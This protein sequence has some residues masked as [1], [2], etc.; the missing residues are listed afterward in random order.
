MASVT[1]QQHNKGKPIKKAKDDK[2]AVSSAGLYK[3]HL[4]FDPD[5]QPYQNI[6]SILQAICSSR[7]QINNFETLEINP[8]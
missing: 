5:T 8:G 7:H 2:V 4:Y 3:N 6:I 1:R